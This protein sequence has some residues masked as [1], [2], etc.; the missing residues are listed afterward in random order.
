MA[1]VAPVTANMTDTLAS[2]AL[3]HAIHPLAIATTVPATGV[4]SP[5]SKNAPE[6]APAVFGTIC[7]HAVVSDRQMIT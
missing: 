7:A 3:D 5:N 1:N 2:L 6:T 4:Q